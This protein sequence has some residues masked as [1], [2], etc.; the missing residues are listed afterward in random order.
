LTRADRSTM[1]AFQSTETTT[2]E[3][4]P[5]RLVLLDICSA[6]SSAELAWCSCFT[7]FLS[8]DTSLSEKRLKKEKRAQDG[9]Q[10]MI[11]YKAHALAVREKTAR[12]K[13]LR[14]ARGASVSA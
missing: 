6:P 14:L 13:A 10:A 5:I 3:K 4:T 7:N 12:L 1:P 11:E 2:T 9:R 8:F